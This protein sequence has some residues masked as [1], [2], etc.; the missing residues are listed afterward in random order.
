MTK[1]LKHQLLKALPGLLRRFDLVQ[2][3]TILR[4]AISSANLVNSLT[5]SETIEL[6]RECA[7]VLQISG[8]VHTGE[9]GPF[10]GA[11][12]D[13]SVHG[14]YLQTNEWSPALQSLLRERVFTERV[15][16]YVDVGANIGLTLIPIAKLGNIR[17][18]GIEP[19][20]RNFTLLRVN[21]LLNE[22][23]DKVELLN[24]A[25]MSA[26]GE[27]TMELSDWNF[28]DHRI[29]LDGQ[30]D[31][32]NGTKA[33]PRLV[34]VR[35]APIDDLIDT[36]ALMRPIVTKVDTQGAEIEVLGGARTLLELT[37]ILI[38]EFWPFGLKRLG[39]KPEDLLALLKDFRF[40]A[41]TKL[42]DQP[43]A[44]LAISDPVDVIFEEALRRSAAARENHYWDL[45]VTKLPIDK[46][47][48]GG[49]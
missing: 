32:S 10:C 37:D 30:D 6:L 25:A 46:A 35:A 9:L 48:R 24:Y 27:V 39:G 36:T 31:A 22:V 13:Q 34:R 41:L 8:Y 33:A 15:G 47:P 3:T 5:R 11:V 2:R 38:L 40:A 23:A 17:C 43:Q 14:H 20:P 45:I 49:G 29:R 21:C 28:G 44:A 7:R 42:D 26:P 12:K 18:I 1:Y 4:K 16:T 19:E